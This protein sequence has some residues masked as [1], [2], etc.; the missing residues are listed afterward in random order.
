MR[1]GSAVLK[2]SRN[3]RPF[4]IHGHCTAQQ[5]E[6]AAAAAAAAV[7]AGTDPNDR[8]GHAEEFASTWNV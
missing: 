6:A 2:N 3:A 7:A 5:Q 4:T 8:V 1:V